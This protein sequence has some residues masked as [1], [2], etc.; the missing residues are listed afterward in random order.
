M[1]TILAANG[2]P[3]EI[4]EGSFAGFNN[5]TSLHRSVLR[6]IFGFQLTQKKMKALLCL[7]VVTFVNIYGILVKILLTTGTLKSSAIKQILKNWKLDSYISTIVAG[8]PLFY[9]PIDLSI[10]MTVQY[11][12]RRRLELV[13]V[14]STV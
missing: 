3:I 1:N 10:F 13:S 11:L 2:S 7:R 4:S 8:I 5:W 9:P 14:P 6:I 12:R